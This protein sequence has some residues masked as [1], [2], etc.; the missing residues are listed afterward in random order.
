M[1]FSV[2]FKEHVNIFIASLLRLCRGEALENSFLGIYSL[3]YS[4]FVRHFGAI[5]GQTNYTKRYKDQTVSPE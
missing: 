3:K 4:D 2:N 5:L 1:Y